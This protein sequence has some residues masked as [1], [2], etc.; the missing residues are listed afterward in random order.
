MSVLAFMV[1][2]IGCALLL[3]WARRSAT[4]SYGYDKPQR[5]H[6]G[7]VPRLGVCPCTSGWLSPG[8]SAPG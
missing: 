2:F 4:S 7:E 6:M 8:E 5:F 1:S 3:R